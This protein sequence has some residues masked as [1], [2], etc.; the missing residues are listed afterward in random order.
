MS[1]FPLVATLSTIACITALFAADAQVPTIERIT[2]IGCAECAAGP[3]QLTTIYDVAVTDSGD[4]VVADRSP[5][6]IR[7]FDRTGRVLWSGGQSGGGPGEYRF[8][9]R[10]AIGPDRSITVVDMRARRL[11]RLNRDG[12]VKASEPILAFPAA[13]AARGRSG[14]L[15]LM[16]DDFRGPYALERWGATADK[17]VPHA[18]IPRPASP[19]GPGVIM[20]SIAVAPSG[21][22]AFG[23]DPF[24]YRIARLGPDAKPLPDIVRDIPRQKRSEAEMKE[25][26]DRM[27]LGPARRGAEASVS[28]APAAGGPPS[29]DLTMKPFFPLDGLR[30]D[31]SGRLWVLTTR[32]G[33]Q[34]TVFDLFAPAGGFLGSVTLPAH[35][36]TFALA[37]TFLATGG[38]DADGIPHVT[39]WRVK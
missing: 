36:G 20:P 2:R 29:V 32:G 34:Q 31:D 17:T 21:I 13:A 5:P 30:Y 37:G 19:V 8:P 25:L 24:T 15:V 12:T 38:E 22:I 28:R 1:R 33:E 27:S 7:V 6:M 14:E 11:T 9:M 3:M 26:A 35:V 4:I 18:T 10:V 16:M 39:L 23:T